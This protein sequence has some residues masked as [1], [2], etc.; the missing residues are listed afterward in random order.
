MAFPRR[1]IRPTSR[2]STWCTRCARASSPVRSST[3]A[4]SRPS[5]SSRRWT[6][7]WKACPTPD[8][9]LGQ[10]GRRP[11]PQDRQGAR[12]REANGVQLMKPIARPRRAARPRGQGSRRLRDEGARGHQGRE[13]R[14][15]SPRSSISSSPSPSRSRMP[16]LVA[17]LEPEV[18]ISQPAQGGGRA[19]AARRDQE[20]PRRRCRRTRRRS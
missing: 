4:F 2:C 20:A 7:R 10:E 3:S 8:V 5:S 16:S 18:S 13:C 11:L 14:P 1:A 9:P 15:V 6:A 19:A 12:G 17:I